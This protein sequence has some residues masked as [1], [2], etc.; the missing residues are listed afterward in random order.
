M[1]VSTRTAGDITEY[2]DFWEDISFSA[3]MVDAG[4]LQLGNISISYSDSNSS[5]VNTQIKLYEVYNNT[6]TE[7]DSYS[8]ATNSFSRTV[9]SINTS[10]YHYIKLWFNT[11][12]SYTITSPV[13]LPI[14][15]LYKYIKD[16][17]LDL[18]TKLDNAL[19]DPPISDYTWTQHI[20]VILPIIVLVLLGVFNT[21]AGIVGCGLSIGLVN[22]VYA[23][24]GLD[25]NIGM[26]PLAV[27]I[28]FIGILYIWTTREGV[29]LL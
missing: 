4:F 28:I 21:G 22:G 20:A 24:Y 16:S 12:A 15:S 5:T 13:T 9:S 6:I 8:Q 29:E 25:V 7:I 10:R 19:G 26:F 27:L 1:P 14:Y 23:G 18:N 11:T 2:D 3:T 17:A